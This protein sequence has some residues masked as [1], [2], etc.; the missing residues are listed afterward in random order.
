[1]IFII[2]VIAEIHAQMETTD[3]NISVVEA[4]GDLGPLLMHD[5]DDEVSIITTKLSFSSFQH[6]L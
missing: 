2:I 4:T 1:M 5:P 3:Q 6:Y